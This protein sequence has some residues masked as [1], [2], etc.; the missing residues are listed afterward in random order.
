M[1]A[2]RTA[3][4][5]RVLAAALGT[6]FYRPWLEA[7]ALDSPEKIALL[8]DPAEALRFL[9]PLPAA[10]YARRKEQFR[11]FAFHPA[12]SAVLHHPL[13]GRPRIAVLASGFRT[14][15]RIR[16]FPDGLDRA[17]ARFRPQAVAG[18]LA[19]IE[20][21]AQQVRTGALRLT[22]PTHALIVL[23]RPDEPLLEEA[24]R[25]RLWDV[26]Q[27]PVYQQVVG[28]DGQLLAWECEAHDG[29]HVAGE[30]AIIESWEGPEGSSLLV[31]SLTDSAFPMLRL[32]TPWQG[33]LAHELCG[34]GQPGERIRARTLHSHRQPAAATGFLE[35]RAAAGAMVS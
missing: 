22:A 21:L 5:R 9:P 10:L 2:A 32:K 18:P 1:Q 12:R 4:L 28:F 3:N 23:T 30:H 24:K 33:T 29:L 31:S 26:F 16:A 13:P 7:A 6:D 34:C 35:A 17:L 15:H 25:E 14:T 11:S 8:G 20:Q 19:R 27:V